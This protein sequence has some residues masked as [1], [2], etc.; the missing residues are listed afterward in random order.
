MSQKLFAIAAAAFIASALFFLRAPGEPGVF[1]R[2]FE[3][4]WSAGRAVNTGANPYAGQL[5]QFERA[6]PGVDSKVNELLP[7]A[8]TPPS[9]A[10]WSALARMQYSTAARYWLV[11]LAIALVALLLAAMRL[12]IGAQ[13]D[14]WS[15][16]ALAACALAFVPVTSDFALGQAALVAYAAA[17]VAIASVPRSITASMVALLLGALQPNVALGAGVL[18]A[19]RRGMAAA[20]IA[21]VVLYATGAV[22]QGLNWPAQYAALLLAHGA[23]ERFDAIQYTPASIAFGFGAAPR[24]ATF[25]GAFVAVAAAVTAAFAI[26]RTGELASKFAVACTALPLV[27]GFMHEHDLVLLLIPALWALRRV[28][29]RLRAATIFAFALCSV[30]WMDFAQQPQAAS[31]DVTLAAGF[32]C[33]ALAWS[34][35][36]DAA[37]YTGAAAAF[38]CVL[39]G[40]WI[41]VHHPAPIWPNDMA[42]FSVAPGANAS[43]IWQAEQRA[44]GLETAAPAWAMLR[45]FSLAGTVMLLIAVSRAS[46]VVNRVANHPDL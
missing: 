29:R 3:A 4:Y 42:A 12:C 37:L 11:A 45:T 32:C 21:I 9:L 1:T 8:G 23:A 10:L 36:R 40:A 14:G 39:A 6:V 44:T 19:H 41:G 31:Q 33:A 34:Q 26:V 16:F 43:Q 46:Y 24:F 22:Y 5:L 2:D 25:A 35:Y 18:V 17:A 30:N 28:E 27:A 38:T 15:F 20:A 13:G 7:F